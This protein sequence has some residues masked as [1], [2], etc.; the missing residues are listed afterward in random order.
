MIQYN[1][2]KLE[3][4]TLALEGIHEIDRLCRKFPKQEK[5]ILED[6]LKRACLSIALNIAEGSGRGTKLDFRRFIRNEIGS[7]LEVVAGIRIAISKRYFEK[8]DSRLADGIL[9]K[10]YFKSLA[11][12]KYLKR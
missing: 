11:M 4:W 1:F 6:Q 9:E 10:L 7:I 12:E 2:E 3:I 8:E 5:Y